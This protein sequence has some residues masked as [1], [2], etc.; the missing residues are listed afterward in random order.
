MVSEVAG[1]TSTETEHTDL[2]LRL[3]DIDLNPLVKAPVPFADRFE[4]VRK[5]WTFIARL[6]T[7]DERKD[8]G[9]TALIGTVAF[10]LGALSPEVLGGGRPDLVGMTTVSGAAYVQTLLSMAMWGWFVVRLWTAFPVMRV[11]VLTMFVCWGLMMG[12]QL[13]FHIENANFP[14]DVALSQLSTGSLLT[15][16]AVFMLYML[17]T[18]VRETRDMHVEEFHVHEDV[19]RMSA[20]MEEHSLYGWGALFVVWFALVTLNAWSGAHFVAERHAERW[21]VLTLHVITAPIIVGSMLVVAWFPQRM[22]GTGA[23][24]RTR[25]ARFADADLLSSNEPSHNEVRLDC[26]SCGLRSEDLRTSANGSVEQRC[27]ASGCKGWGPTGTSC[28]FCERPLPSRL[29]CVGCGINTPI[30]EF[31]SGPEV[32]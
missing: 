21:G 6:S 18:A 5:E 12:A 3:S 14:L 17:G 10:L 23:T 20:E 24:V 2:R 16:V 15:I 22:L 32:W 31:L 1:V 7:L 27:L 13:L 26:P 25:A 4:R 28:T 8:G 19:R 29:T 9:V 30:A 11:H